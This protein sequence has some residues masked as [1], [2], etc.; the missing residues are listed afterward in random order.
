[1]YNSTLGKCTI[2]KLNKTQNNEIQETQM[3]LKN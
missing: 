1:M 3:N 2:M